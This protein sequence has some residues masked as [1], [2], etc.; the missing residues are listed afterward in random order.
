MFAFLRFEQHLLAQVSWSMA[1]SPAL[2]LIRLK[3][4][5]TGV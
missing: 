1:S 4:S 5:E 3:K 2:A